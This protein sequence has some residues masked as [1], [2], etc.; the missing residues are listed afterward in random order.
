MVTALRPLTTGELLDRTF[1]LYRDHFVLFVG[2][3]ALPQLVLLAYQL[4]AAAFRPPGMAFAAALWTIVSALGAWILSL[5]AG[6][7]AQSAT[8]MA[9]SQVHLGRPT[10]VMESYSQ[11]KHRIPAIVGM[12]FVIGLATG[13]GFV[14]C[15]V[16]GVMLALMWALAIPAAILENKGFGD[17]LSRSQDL[18]KGDRWR[19]FLVLLLFGI[20]TISMTLLIQWPLVFLVTFLTKGSYAPSSQILV[21]VSG[22]IAGFFS[23]CLATPLATIALSLVYYDERVRKEAFD[24]QLMM[25][26][27]DGNPGQAPA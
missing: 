25:S 22:A 11:V 14:L 8:V 9:V 10:S 7:A 3:A 1:S 2:I 6:G 15:I 17:A 24:M 4:A 27:L 12:T 26:T 16:P 5:I 21:Q 20:L 19:I 18:T 23:N 13:L